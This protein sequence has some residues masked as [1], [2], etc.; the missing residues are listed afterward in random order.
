MNI[1]CVK[2]YVCLVNR[3]YDLKLFQ[4]EISEEQRTYALEVDDIH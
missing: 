1:I 3:R 4:I 2:H